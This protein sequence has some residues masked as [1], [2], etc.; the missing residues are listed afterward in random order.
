MAL[1]FPTNPSTG[2]VYVFG[3]K[4]YIWNGHGWAISQGASGTTVGTFT[5]TQAASITTSTNSTGTSSGALVV[6]GGVGIGG[7]VNVG[8]SINAG[9]TSTV[10]GSQIVTTGTLAQIIQ[11]GADTSISTS[12][13]LL[14][15]SNTST[16]QSITGRGS[17][18][19]NPISFLNTS[20]SSVTVSGGF[21]A[22]GGIDAQSP[23]TI[24]STVS[25]TSTTTGALVV[26]GGVGVSGEVFIGGTI[27]AQQLKITDAVMDSSYILVNTTATTVIDTYLIT[28]YR[29]AKYL[30]Q[31]EEMGGA[32]DA[33]FQAIEL[34]MIVDNTGAV[35]LTEYGLIYTS[36]L[37]GDFSAG[38][39]VIDNTV[40]LYFTPYHATDK[41]IV[42]LR[43]AL[44]M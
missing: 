7:N 22:Q 35:S 38:L 13:N 37:M 8:G 27:N 9:S 43:T 39:N 2:T 16:L 21:V 42:V 26:S 5:A 44:A 33:K 14:T 25:S 29:T 6:T 40:N 41:E 34:L 12:N 1:G 15:I 3:T 17:S 20:T 32:I 36:S 19:T 23:I 30:I 31:I 11:A 28:Q 18:T 24:T 4:T 10:G